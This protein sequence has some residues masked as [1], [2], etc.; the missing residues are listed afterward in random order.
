MGDESEGSYQYGEMMC[1]LAGNHGAG[2]CFIDCPICTGKA[3]WVTKDGQVIPVRDMTDDHLRNTVRYL[4]RGAE[5]RIL[6]EVGSMSAYADAHDGT[7]AADTMGD[8]VDE[9]AE[10]PVDEY[11]A[12]TLPVFDALLME[13]ASRGITL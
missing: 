5:R 11:L 4:R 7:V 6:G 8:V 13:A 1:D 3:T 2:Q 10:M 12:V 9:L